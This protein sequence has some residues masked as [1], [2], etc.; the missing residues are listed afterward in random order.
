MTD[1]NIEEIAIDASG[2]LIVR[3]ERSSFSDLYQAGAFGFRWDDATA[4]LASPKP[5]EWSYLNWFEHMLAVIAN[6]YG[7]ALK[8]AYSTKWTSVPAGVREELEAFSTSGWLEKLERK[9]SD[10]AASYWP[11]FEVD[12]ALRR[13]E[14]HCAR[15]DFGEVC[16]VLEQVADRLSPAQLKRLEI[17]RKRAASS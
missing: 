1:E 7:T 8:T 16:R 15:N 12:Q 13:A 5:K 10:D 11:R 9:H 4:A 2:G 3:P 14:R 17:A 6:N